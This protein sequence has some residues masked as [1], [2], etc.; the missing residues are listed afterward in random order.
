M[1]LLAYYIYTVQ[2]CFLEFFLSDYMCCLALYSVPYL[3]LLRDIVS[4]RFHRTIYVII[5]LVVN[6][7]Y[8]R[9][10]PAHFIL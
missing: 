5:L 4:H 6:R 2:S 10:L 8:L 9:L 3:P 1:H 7:S